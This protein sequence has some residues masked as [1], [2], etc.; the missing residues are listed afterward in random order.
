MTVWMAHPAHL[1]IL[2]NSHLPWKTCQR[3]REN[4]RG[5]QV[6]CLLGWGSGCWTAVAWQAVGNVGF[7]KGC[8]SQ[9]YISLV[10]PFALNITCRRKKCWSVSALRR[11]RLRDGQNIRVGRLG[12]EIMLN[13]WVGWN[14]CVAPSWFLSLFAELSTWEHQ[15]L[16]ASE[17]AY[18][19]LSFTEFIEIL[20]GYK[21][22]RCSVH[23]S[24]A[25]WLPAW[26]FLFLNN[27][28]MK[29]DIGICV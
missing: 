20:I 23:C 17:C 22:E 27:S 4:L 6:P 11:V 8:W 18:N 7:N 15:S 10:T 1:I 12:T 25:V 16:F 24:E 19:C 26:S 14:S 2:L 3:R 28:H 13:V 9:V 5:N 29:R 21:A